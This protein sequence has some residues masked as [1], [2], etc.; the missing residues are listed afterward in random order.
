M[1]M[2]HVHSVEQDLAGKWYARVCISPDE[3]AFLKFDD[4][5]TMNEIQACAGRAVEARRVANDKA[6]A[7]VTE[8][9]GGN[10]LDALGGGSAP[11]V[12]MR[13]RGV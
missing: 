11:V 4:F 2:F 10:A 1:T 3:A 13:R 7:V 6:A 9:A 8:A 5:P 12:S